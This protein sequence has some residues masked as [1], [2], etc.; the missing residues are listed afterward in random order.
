[1]GNIAMKEKGIDVIV[2]AAGKD[3][4]F[5]PKVVKYIKKNLCEINIIY[6]ITN[7]ANISKTEKILRKEKVEGTVLLDENS[8]IEGLTYSSV[9]ESLIKREWYV[10]PGW[11]FQQFLK[12]GFAL[13]KYAREY[14]LSWDAD[15]L[16]LSQLRFIE[17]GHPLFTSKKEYHAAYF[18]TMG[19][20]LGLG[21][22]F[23][24][25]F[26]AEHMLFKTS[27]MRELIERIEANRDIEGKNWIEKCINACEFS[28][29]DIYKE[30]YFSEFE[31]YGTY[32]SVYYPDLYKVRQLNTFR[33]AGYIRG[34]NISDEM[35]ERIALDLDIASFEEGDTPPFPYNLHILI[36]K[37]IFSKFE[38]LRNMPIGKIPEY[39][40]SM[41]RR[42][43]HL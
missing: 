43:L 1:M 23:E 40:R 24:Y 35:L 34:R 2:P 4:P 18:E 15:T 14:Y 10:R 13:S 21:K 37:K 7:A 31:T 26:I 29:E 32:A 22:I 5:I 42:R 38:K 8:L 3:I 20:L 33:K 19:K 39:F 36:R 30:P 6:I 9:K 27:I 25:S 12:M 16:P 11:Y 28:K 17:K 41:L